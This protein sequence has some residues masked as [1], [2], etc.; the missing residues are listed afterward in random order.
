MTA[1]KTD[2]AHERAVRA[3]YVKAAQSLIKENVSE[4][5]NPRLSTDQVCMLEEYQRKIAEIDRK[6]KVKM[7]TELV[8]QRLV[9]EN[10]A[11]NERRRL[12]KEST[13]IMKKI[14]QEREK[15]ASAKKFGN[16]TERYLNAVEE[17]DNI[18]LFADEV[19][20]QPSSYT[21]AHE[22]QDDDIVEEIVTGALGRPSEA[23]NNKLITA[24]KTRSAI[25]DV[26]IEDTQ[27]LPAV[28]THLP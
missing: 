2:I 4:T 13:P 28:P 10:E 6:I 8:L 7:P 14:T 15:V 18:L 5:R 12:L 20:S 19:V 24:I 11:F 9:L 27:L 23:L 26:P 22:A 3:L 17:D 25:C 16:H 1:S 21:S